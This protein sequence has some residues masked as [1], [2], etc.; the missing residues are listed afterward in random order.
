MLSPL[1][2]NLG[3]LTLP[4]RGPAFDPAT[5]AGLK[6]WLKADAGALNASDL[7]ATDTEAVKTWQDQSGNGWHATQATAGNRPAWYIGASSN[8]SPV[9]RFDGVDDYFQL[10]NLMSGAAAGTAFVVLSINNDPPAP[11]RSSGPLSR[12]GTPSNA[13]Y[14]WIDG[15][16]YDDFGSTVRKDAIAVAPSLA[17]WRVYEVLSAAGD[18]RNYL[19]G[20]LLHATTSNTVAWGAT[21]FIGSN[22]LGQYFIDG[23]IA[24]VLVYAAALSDADRQAVESYLMSKYAI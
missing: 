1:A 9:V 13:H 23:D 11:D 8:G 14:P 2:H 21:P 7:A 24:E 4:L 12:F 17:A 16:I 10:G 6:L 20:S 22:G 5:I 3:P 19:D 15:A 18:W